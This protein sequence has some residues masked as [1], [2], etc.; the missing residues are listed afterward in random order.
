MLGRGAFHADPEPD[1]NLSWSP[2][3]A[4]GRRGHTDASNRC[5]DVV[6]SFHK[7]D[8]GP[9]SL[10]DGGRILRAGASAD[11]HRARLRTRKVAS[12]MDAMNIKID[13]LVFDRAN[14]DADGD[15]LCLARGESTEAADAALTP[16]G[17]GVRYG[18]DGQVIGVT[19][20]NARRCSWIATAT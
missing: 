6:P 15:V 19:I 9:K 7:R 18:D 13:G 20:I 11:H 16:E 14:Y 1:S 2:R 8:A 3:F 12:R 10:A 17:H 4:T 5:R